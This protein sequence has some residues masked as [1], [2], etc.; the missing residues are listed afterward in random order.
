MSGFLYKCIHIL[1]ARYVYIHLYKMYMTLETVY[2]WYEKAIEH[3]HEEYIKT[4]TV[5][6]SESIN[7]RESNHKI[8]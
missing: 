7:K 8:G 3:I 4:T 6:V 2:E 1:I 5:P